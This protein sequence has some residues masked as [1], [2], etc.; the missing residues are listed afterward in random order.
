MVELLNKGYRTDDN[1]GVIFSRMLEIRESEVFKRKTAPTDISSYL[2]T[3]V[4]LAFGAK[5][6]I[7]EYSDRVG[8]ASIVGGS[9]DNI[10]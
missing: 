6:E 9:P 3:T 1:T 7:F 5:K 10:P 2:P 4:D 8:E